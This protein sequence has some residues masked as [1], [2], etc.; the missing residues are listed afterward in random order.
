MIEKKTIL[1]ITTDPCLCLRS[2]VVASFQIRP[3]VRE[4]PLL[5]RL[6]PPESIINTGATVNPVR[7]MHTCR[8]VFI[9][10]YIT[11]RAFVGV[12]SSRLQPGVLNS[13][14]RNTRPETHAQ[15]C[16]GDRIVETGR[17]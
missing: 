13:L 4:L 17:L 1:L 5:L 16:I 10:A 7:R 6:L 15:T 11:R 12:L 14:A 3:R 2:S 9:F 8:S